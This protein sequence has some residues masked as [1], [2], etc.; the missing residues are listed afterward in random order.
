M[1]EFPR[2]DFQSKE[3]CIF[4]MIMFFFYVVNICFKLTV[5][6]EGLMTHIG[7]L[8]LNDHISFLAHQN[9][10]KAENGN[11]GYTL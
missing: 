5:F 4:R 2:E 3:V 10:P 11:F 9:T 7:K 1:F 6:S 8:V